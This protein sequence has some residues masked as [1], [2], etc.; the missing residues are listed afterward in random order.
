MKTKTTTTT[1]N[2]VIGKK[3]NELNSM[4]L[5]KQK[6]NQIVLFKDDRDNREEI[7][8][9]LNLIISLKMLKLKI[10]LKE[11]ESINIKGFVNSFELNNCLKYPNFSKLLQK[12][13]ISLKDLNSK[14]LINVTKWS[15]NVLLLNLYKEIKDLI[16]YINNN[17]KEENLEIIDKTLDFTIYIKEIINKL[18]PSLRTHLRK[19]GVTFMLNTYTGFDTEYQNIDTRI[20]ELLSVQLAVSSRILV[21]IP[22]I[23]SEYQFTKVNT[24]KGTVYK[25][26]N[27]SDTINTE[28]IRQT[29]N[30]QI[31][32]IRESYFKE[33][34]ESLENIIKGLKDLGIPHTINS[35]S[36]VFMFE[37]S[38]L[39]TWFF[40]NIKE[41]GIGL[42]DLL[43]KSNDMSSSYLE[44]GLEN[45]Y[46]LFKDIFNHNK[47]A[48]N[49]PI[50]F[51]KDVQELE[52]IEFENIYED[53]LI[54]NSKK[55]S[56]T[57]KQSFS[58]MKV[59][60]TIVR[61]NYFIG[62]LTSADLSMLNDFENLKNYFDIVNGSFVTL[63][64]PLLLDNVNLILR[65]T[66]LLSPGGQKSLKSIGSLYGK[67]FQKI[68]IGVNIMNMKKFLKE[69]YE[70]FK[71]YA[72][73]DSV[74]CLTHAL[75]MEEF[76]FKMGVVGI[77]LT[78][79][80]VSRA[81][82]KNKW[83]ID[84]YKGYQ[85]S[86][87]YLI[88]EIS[89]TQTPRGL[90]SVGLTGLYTSF[91]IANY[92]GGRN[93][94]FMYGIDRT[95]KWFDYDL[96]SA[97]TTGMALLGDPD[98]AKGSKLTIKQLDSLK[99]ESLVLSYTVI[100]TS[101][102]F[103]KNTKYP[104]IPCFVDEV[105]TVYPLKG[106]AILTGAEYL[107]AK[108]QGCK[109]K[110]F[111]IFSIPFK[112]PTKDKDLIIPSYKPF[113]ST[114]KELQSSRAEHA[115]GS[116]NNLI[117]KELGNSL[118]GLVVKGISN[119]MKFD[120]RLKTTVRMEAGY[121][122]NPILASWITGFIRSVLGELLHNT[123]LLKGSI[124]SVTTDGFI[125]DIENLEEK[126]LELPN[127][128]LNL[129]NIYKKSRVNLSNISNALE[130]KK[131]GK[132]IFSWTTRGQFSL[133]S[134][135]MAATG[136][137]RNLFN[138][139][140]IEELFENTM[141]SNNKEI[142]YIN[143]RLRSALEIFKK[144]GHV[145]SVYKDQVFRLV[146]DNRRKIIQP[147]EL[148]GGLESELVNKSILL[149]S[150][151]VED[152]NQAKLY[153][154]LGKLNKSTVYQKNSS[155]G[156]SYKNTYVNKTDI[157]I[158]NFVRGLLNGEFNLD[159][160]YFKNYSEICSFINNYKH[161]IESIERSPEE[162]LKSK[163]LLITPNIVA[164]LKRRS[165]IPKVLINNESTEK[166]IDYVKET[167]PDFDSNKFYNR[168]K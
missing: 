62:H 52:E 144:G 71:A 8:K 113:L 51:E 74:I 82:V 72:I 114:I 67:E 101:F 89:K 109:F 92:K 139:N 10:I 131:E 77:P 133:D 13:T 60:V 162:R 159:N 137:Q 84:N 43:K 32:S 26:D 122:S 102:E 55:F 110:I 83:M 76:V 57:N 141:N 116:I 119:K 155:I 145:T 38:Q 165:V 152:I 98:Y 88:G 41:E 4:V 53:R 6:Q 95:K 58:S 148:E 111:D 73:Q 70:T 118:Y 31:K 80:S 90:H 105:T 85:L 136:F 46:N 126:I 93:E 86:S 18:D 123:Y 65:D 66:M 54:K 30:Q 40:S 121:L 39:N 63:K 94:S 56:R 104:S 42:E 2:L 125:T 28:L 16:R 22:L 108:E 64:T 140:E 69:D 27:L 29:L 142:V 5:Y 48:S 150:H 157:A 132:S 99:K 135:I 91:Y 130:I 147:V 127:D 153:R 156:D 97:Y 19:S 61:N 107:L 128:R 100:K 160:K 87:E 25:V 50:I 23:F 167:F 37:K 143:H 36:I 138:L 44:L 154:Y 117:Y 103:P 166:F 120:T 49:T 124:V 146:F 34:D 163:F 14:D 112:L 149:D 3:S 115:K 7:T 134:K 106:E 17:N 21:K 79:S 151:P 24:L 15:Y 20:N 33:Y 158:R 81:Y 59:V 68:D 96:I 75:F 35:D 9:S 45:I 12:F 11:I 1:M 164:Q 78:L 47:G 168:F 161:H 129:L